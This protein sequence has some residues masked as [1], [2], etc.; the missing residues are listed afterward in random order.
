M[1]SLF[2]LIF[3]S[4]STQTN[5]LTVSKEDHARKLLENDSVTS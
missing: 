3:Q 4:P 5:S 1:F 2:S